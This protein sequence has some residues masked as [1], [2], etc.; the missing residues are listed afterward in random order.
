MLLA[1]RATTYA[2]SGRVQRAE[3]DL[4]AHQLLS[5]LAHVVPSLWVVSPPADCA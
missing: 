1:G 5:V 2:D 4:A 3:D